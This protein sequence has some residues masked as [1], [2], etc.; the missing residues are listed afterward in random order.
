M[1]EQKN[2]VATV[3]QLAGDF[4]QKFGKSLENYA[5][6]KYDA[7]SFLK[8]AMIA[9]ADNIDL[10]DCLKTDAGKASLF[11]A[12]RYAATTGLS[13]NPQEGKAAL[14]AYGGKVKYQVMKNGMTEIALESGKVEF[15]TADYVKKNDVFQI[16]KTGNGDLYQHIPALDDRGELVGFYAALRLK[17]GYTHAK[18]MTLAEV[19]E[20]RNKY[21]AMYKAAPE[22]SAWNK[23]FIG[24]ALKTVT[25]A[26][27]RN[28]RI[29]DELDNAIGAD[30]F[31]EAEFKIEKGVSAEAAKEKLQAKSDPAAPTTAKEG[32]LL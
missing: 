10:T 7:S 23:S 20:I 5:M 27:L 28:V 22:K 32:D 2:Q 4:L 30:D 18:W 21:S 16:S 3:D 17:G 1:A 12:L 29:S 11:S 26:L 6:R 13:L 15:V 25:K 9:I 19:E 14:I 24:M 8:S 31:Y